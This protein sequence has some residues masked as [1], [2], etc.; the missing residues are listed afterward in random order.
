MPSVASRY[1]PR[2]IHTRLQ[3]GNCT[4]G[5]GTAPDETVSIFTDPAERLAKGMANA[6]D[7]LLL[8]VRIY[9]KLHPPNTTST[10]MPERRSLLSLHPPPRKMRRISCGAGTSCGDPSHV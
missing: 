2:L 8:D 4:Q 7:L 6:P 3:S 5:D 1:M 9:E 10:S